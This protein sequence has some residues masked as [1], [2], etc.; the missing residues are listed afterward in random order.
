MSYEDRISIATP[1]GVDLQL[2]LAG[3]GSRTVARLIDQAIQTGV[4]IAVMV[5]AALA[6]GGSDGDGAGLAVAG[7]LVLLFLVQFGYDVLFETLASGRTP[8]KRWSGLRV[9]RVDGGPVGFLTSAVRNLLRL[10]DFLPG[11][12]AV[13]MVV[14]L[15]SPRNQR[16]GDL[17]AGTLVVRERRSGGKV[18]EAAGARSGAWDVDD[19]VAGWDVSAV[20]GD[21]LATVRRFLERGATLTVEA[22]DRLAE[23]LAGRLR[24]KV[25]GPPSDQAAEQFLEHLVAAKSAR[26]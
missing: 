14:V 25:V 9:V 7:F 26:L 23:Q 2:T 11:V 24:P 15:A 8:G 6:A 17:A 10:V 19:R 22:R 21:E 20:T 5:L 12:Y 18:A 3:L 13:G 16:L 1:E 4:L